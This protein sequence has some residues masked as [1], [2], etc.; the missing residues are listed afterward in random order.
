LLR[1]RR[2]RSVQEALCSDAH[3]AS[4]YTYAEATWT[5]GLADWIGS[6]VRTFAFIGGVTAQTVSDN[7]KSGITK[8]CFYEPTVN[9]TYAE[10]KHDHAV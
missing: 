8:A 5:Q 9:R 7:L 6:H 10:I 3:N 4:S 1:L 2:S